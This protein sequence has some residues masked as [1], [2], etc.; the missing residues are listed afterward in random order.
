VLVIALVCTLSCGGNHTTGPSDVAA[1]ANFDAVFSVS[2]LDL[3]QVRTL[4]PLGHINPPGHV[5]PTDHVY[6]YQVDIDQPYVA[7][8]NVLNVYAPASGIVDWMLTI[9]P[10]NDVKVDFRVNGRFSYYVDHLFP[11]ANIK[12]GTMVHAGD[13]IGTTG[14]GASLDLGAY[15][16]AVTLPGLISPARYP[17]QTLHCV[18]PWQYFAEPIRSQIYSR[19]R[20]VPSAPDRDGR[21]DYDIAGRLVGSWF[22]DSVTGLDSSGPIG[23]P[24][25]LAF[26]YDYND[27]SLVRI[28]IGGT[29]AAP[30]VWTIDPLAPR[31]EN[32]TVGSGKVVYRLMYTGST[33]VQS[34]LMVVQM[35]DDMTIRVEVWE[36]SQATDADFDSRAMT[37]RR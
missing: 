35:I 21:I 36:G 4:T 20:R 32:V 14:P 9:P 10:I 18:S 31:P 25:S 11:A 34:G 12:V 33:N 28:S 6:F 1:G 24:K 13:L 29:I 22:H 30:G 3:S 37:Y 8:S 5:L 17:S 16:L 26:A 27:P 19:I 15:D 2:P 7:S 23:W